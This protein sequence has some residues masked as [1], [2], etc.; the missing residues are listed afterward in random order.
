MG[1]FT[2]CYLLGLY[3][4]REQMELCLKRLENAR[5]KIKADVVQLDSMWEGPAHEI[6][7]R[8]WQDEITLIDNLIKA[9]RSL[10]KFEDTAYHEYS[11][12]TTHTQQLIEGLK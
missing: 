8:E 6:F 12:T 3:K 4:T 11:N 1:E 5:D 9:Y 7:K 10:V 2:T